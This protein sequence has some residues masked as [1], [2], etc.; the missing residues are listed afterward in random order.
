MRDFTS[1]RDVGGA[2]WGA[3]LASD[4]G[5]IA[6]PRIWPSL[7]V[8]SQFGGLTGTAARVFWLPVNLV[9]RR[10]IWSVSGTVASPTG[11]IRYWLPLEKISRRAHR[12]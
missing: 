1:L 5:E 12:S 10:I 2:S 9:G 3:K 8:I 11:V 6:G 7:R 4:R